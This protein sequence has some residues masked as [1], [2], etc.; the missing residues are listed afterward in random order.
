[1]PRACQS[2]FTV[3]ALLL[4][5]PVA[6]GQSIPNNPLE[7]SENEGR[8]DQLAFTKWRSSS[9][10]AQGRVVFVRFIN[11]MGN[12]GLRS[13]FVDDLGEEFVHDARTSLGEMTALTS[14]SQGLQEILAFK[15]PGAPS[16]GLFA[17]DLIVGGAPRAQLNSNELSPVTSTS[18]VGPSSGFGAA[19]L[20]AERSTVSTNGKPRIAFVSDQRV[21]TSNRAEIWS[22]DS[23]LTSDPPPNHGQLRQIIP[24]WNSRLED[25]VV[26]RD[27]LA[28]PFLVL[29][30]DEVDPL[31]QLM[32]ASRVTL[33]GGLEAT[34]AFRDMIAVVVPPAVADAGDPQDEPV[35]TL[36]YR[37]AKHG[38]TI[39]TAGPGGF[40]AFEGPYFYVHQVFEGDATVRDEN[41]RLSILSGSADGSFAAVASI[42]VPP[43]PS[44][45]AIASMNPSVDPLPDIVCT[46]YLDGTV[47]VLF[48]R[49]GEGRLPTGD[50]PLVDVPENPEE[51]SVESTPFG[52]ASGDLNGD[53]RH[54]IVTAN[55]DENTFTIV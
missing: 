48:G 22:S 9:E 29:D 10:H 26:T 45:V 47:G 28:H 15:I 16:P 40:F 55:A 41:S 51:P 53:G 21:L 11:P 46:S 39:T 30:A 44:D 31:R 43:V 1:M 35:E 50:F 38:G 12:V 5:V 14:D 25:P 19:I 32:V 36:E 7:L 23:L 37:V 24:S 49:E 3:V 42:D 52:I 54:E 18:P 13:V 34:G 8:I 33:T 4:T 17:L 27:R 20:F 2:V 6:M